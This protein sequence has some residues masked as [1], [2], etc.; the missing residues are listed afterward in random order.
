MKY[1]EVGKIVSTHGI[2]GELKVKSTTSFS[3]KRYKKDANLYV[4]FQGTKERLQIST[5]RVHKGMDLIGFQG[6]S[7]IND[8]IRFIGTTLYVHTNDLEELSDNEFYYDELI[9]MNVVLENQEVI[10]VVADIK[11]V[12]QGEILVIKRENQKNALVPFIQQFVKDVSKEK[13]QIVITPIEGL[14]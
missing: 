4:D 9:G 14:L 11:E 1:L 3:E 2:K 10:G 12:P 5:H 13:N 7:D 8:V 6:Y